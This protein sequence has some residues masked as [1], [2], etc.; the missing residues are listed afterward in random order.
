MHFLRKKMDMVLSIL[1]W[2]YHFQIRSL[3]LSTVVQV[4]KFG[5]D[6]DFISPGPY[7]ITQHSGVWG[8]Q[9]KPPINNFLYHHH[10]HHYRGQLQ[11]VHTSD[12]SKIIHSLWAFTWFHQ[13][14]GRP[15]RNCLVD[16]MIIFPS[17]LRFS[18]F[19]GFI[20]CEFT[21]Y[22]GRGCWQ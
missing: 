11:S 9:S 17:F 2:A 20:L 22:R 16:Q 5:P 18:K 19:N 7:P 13:K 21:S 15:S 12:S 6:F 4:D 10:H 8:W 1:Q 14:Q 3:P